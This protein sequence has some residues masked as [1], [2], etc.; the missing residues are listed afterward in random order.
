MPTLAI[1]PRLQSVEL[2]RVTPVIRKPEI[3]KHFNNRKQESEHGIVTKTD[4]D[5]SE[6]NYLDSDLSENNYLDSDWS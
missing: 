5:W 2:S 4:S 3:A 1:V 6:Y